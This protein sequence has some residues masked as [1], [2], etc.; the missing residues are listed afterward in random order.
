MNLLFSITLNVTR[1][2]PKDQNLA[3]IEHNKN[4]K[5]NEAQA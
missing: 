2:A 3:V 1:C 5:K 4:N